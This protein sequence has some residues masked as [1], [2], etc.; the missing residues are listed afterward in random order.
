[1]EKLSYEFKNRM[2]KSFYII[3]TI[4]LLIIYNSLLSMIICAIILAASYCMGR[5]VTKSLRFET[6]TALGLGLIGLIM[7]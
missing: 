6:T 2:K 1:M 4:G 5:I 3:T 7:R